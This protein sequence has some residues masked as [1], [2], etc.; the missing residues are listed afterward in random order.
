MAFTIDR[1]LRMTAE[2]VGNH[3]VGDK[4]FN[5]GDI[6]FTVHDVQDASLSTS[7]EMEDA[8]DGQG[9][10]INQYIRSKTAEWSGN[11]ALFDFGMAAAQYGDKATTGSHTVD[12]VEIVEVAA[13]ATSATL[14]G[15]MKTNGTYKVYDIANDGMTLGSVVSNVTI[16]NG[17]ISGLTTNSSVARKYFVKYQAEV[18]GTKIENKAD[19]APIPFKLTVEALGNDTCTKSTSYLY[20]TAPYAKMSPD[21]DWTVETDSTHDFTINCMKNYCGDEGLFTVI[22]A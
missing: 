9:N 15:T 5:E 11:N 21:F 10:I 19:A 18:T 22:K 4:T 17:S 1:V 6:L 14:K 12:K 2:V 20:I 3:T 16:S 13:D 8:V 7:A